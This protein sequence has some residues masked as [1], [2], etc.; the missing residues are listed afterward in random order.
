MRGDV[1]IYRR[2]APPRPER[3]VA[4]EG[5]MR[6]HAPTVSETSSGV[7]FVASARGRALKAASSR[8]RLR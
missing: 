6:C 7:D 1:F 8:S 4:G 2:M 3:F 5:R